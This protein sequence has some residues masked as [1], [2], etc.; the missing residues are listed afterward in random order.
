MTRPSAPGPTS[1]TTPV[2][3]AVAS[4]GSRP[5]RLPSRLDPPDLPSK[6][7]PAQVERPITQP[8][9]PARPRRTPERRRPRRPARLAGNQNLALGDH[10]VERLG[11]LPAPSGRVQGGPGTLPV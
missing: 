2:A 5:V 10:G 3:R 11:H 8:S 4:R 6:V 7:E 9:P 1:P